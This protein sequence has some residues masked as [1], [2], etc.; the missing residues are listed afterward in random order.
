M[1]IVYYVLVIIIFITRLAG[2]PR[3]EHHPGYALFL[4]VVP[5]AYLLAKAPPLQRPALYYVRVFLL[6][7]YLAV[8]ALLD[9]IFK[10]DFRHVR[11]MTIATV[12]LFFAGSGGMLGVASLAVSPGAWR[13][14][15]C[16]WPW[17]Y[18]HS[19]SVPLRACKSAVGDGS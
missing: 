8:E 12:S 14:S 5:L 19:C 15:S 17:S 11:W 7:V 1:A 18:W 10:I 2:R 13:R 3:L 9:Y 4:L 6:L 16:S